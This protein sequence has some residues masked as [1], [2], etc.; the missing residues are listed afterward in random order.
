MPEEPGAHSREDRQHRVDRQ[1]V[2]EPERDPAAHSE[3]QHRG[4]GGERDGEVP[5]PAP[6]APWSPI[7]TQP[8]AAR[9]RKASG[10]LTP[11]ATGKKYH[12][13]PGMTSPSTYVGMLSRL[14]HAR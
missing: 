13:P 14:Y 10:V 11:I 6:A 7:T 9:M 4:G 5:L 1:Q 2:P 3:R 12:A 8:M